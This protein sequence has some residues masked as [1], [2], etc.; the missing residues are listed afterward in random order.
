MSQQLLKYDIFAGCEARVPERGTLWGI[1]FLIVLDVMMA[2]LGTPWGL[3]LLQFY[4]VDD[5]T[6]IPSLSFLFSCIFWF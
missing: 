3:E 6:D 2:L 1:R 5:N 4:Q